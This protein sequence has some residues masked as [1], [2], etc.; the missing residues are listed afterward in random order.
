MPS[1]PPPTLGQMS[2]AALVR[3]LLALSWRYRR[4][5]IEV[6]A[7]QLLLLAMGIGGLGL[8]GL[9]ID[10]IRQ[11]VQPDARPPRWPFGFCPPASWSPMT[12][13]GV[14]ALGVLVLALLRAMLNYLYS[15]ALATLVEQDMITHPRAQVYDKLQR[16]RFRFF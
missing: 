12:V 16:L 6:L 5:C 7:F 3:R 1:N 14:I 15:M 2:N 8:T 10:F 4:G 9:A 11:Q 13:I